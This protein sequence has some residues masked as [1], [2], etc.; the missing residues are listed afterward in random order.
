MTK[1]R[2]KRP[3]VKSAISYFEGRNGERIPPSAYNRNYGALKNAL[4]TGSDDSRRMVTAFAD[5]NLTSPISI[6]QN[7]AAGLSQAETNLRARRL[8]RK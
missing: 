8:A 6:L 5:R 4:R 2:S 1:S 7:V 3:S